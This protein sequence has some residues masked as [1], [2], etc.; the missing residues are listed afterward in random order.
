MEQEIR[1]WIDGAAPTAERVEQL[2]GEFPLFLLPAA[3]RL[4]NAPDLTDE[5]RARL[6][7]IL[8][9]GAAD[10]EQMAMAADTDLRI[11]LAVFYPYPSK[12]TPGTAD[13]IEK[14]LNTYGN[15]SPREDEL[16]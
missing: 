12:N 6:T 1:Q 4:R 15:S 11:D 3:M 16:L 14:F 2:L 9:L 5:E 7:T 13:T 8:A 10:P